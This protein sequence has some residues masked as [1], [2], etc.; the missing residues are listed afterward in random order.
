ME[1]K[2]MFPVSKKVSGKKIKKKKKFRT[3]YE[4]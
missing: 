1:F 2:A 3:E 4:K